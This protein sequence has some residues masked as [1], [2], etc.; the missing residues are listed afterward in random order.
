MLY[1]KFFKLQLVAFLCLVLCTCGGGGGDNA[2]PIAAAG[3]A[4]IDVTNV[5]NVTSGCSGAS[6]TWTAANPSNTEI[7]SCITAASS[8]DTIIVPAGS[9]TWT[10]GI[11]LSSSK[12]ITLQG[13]GATNTVI[14]H[15]AITAISLVGAHRISGIGFT[16]TSSGGTSIEARQQRWRIDHC[17][18]TN[19]TGSSQYAIQANGTNQ[20]VMPAGLIDNN[21]FIEGRIDVSGMGT[22]L[23]NSGFWATD[24]VIGTA[25]Q[26]YIEDNTFYKTVGGGGNVID[27][28]RASSYVARYNTVKGRTEFM[29]HGWQDEDERGTRSWEIYGNSFTAASST[30]TA[31]WMRSG[32]G[33]IAYNQFSN[34]SYDITFD[35]N[36]AAGSCADCD[37]VKLCSGLSYADGNILANGWPCRDQIGR[38]KDAFVWSANTTNPSPVQESSPAYLFVNRRSTGNSSVYAHNGTGAWIQSDRDYYTHNA[39]FNGTSGVGCGTLANRPTSCTPG[40]AYW[41]TNQSCTDTTGMVGA[42]PSNPIKGTLYKCN[43]S[44]QWETHYTPYTYP[45]PLRK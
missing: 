35:D 43:A 29:T 44:G 32:T 5:T 9:A 37:T 11:N 38:G 41:A 30:F 45:H 40:V 10:S 33:V 26:V 24:P 22:F 13:A 15:G 7:S 14:S 25:N 34:Y 39:S 17:S 20:T 2:A 28:G 3:S 1:A 18:F 31:I 42:N 23:K 12:L 21:N 4:T 8:G 6:P 19:S 27:S 36:R 16:L